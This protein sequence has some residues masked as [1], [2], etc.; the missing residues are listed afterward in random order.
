MVR[1][2]T[3]FLQRRGIVEKVLGHLFITLGSNHFFIEMDFEQ[4]FFNS[5]QA[6]QKITVG[7]PSEILLNFFI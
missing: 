6:E 7:L 4:Y 1:S 2:L 3:D 5:L